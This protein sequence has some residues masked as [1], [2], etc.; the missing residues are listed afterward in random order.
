MDITPIDEARYVSEIQFALRAQEIDGARDRD[1]VS[2]RDGASNRDGTKRIEVSPA[3]TTVVIGDV[4]ETV[5]VESL[6]QVE[7]FTRWHMRFYLR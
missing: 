5:R 3:S 1:G 6:C 2:D 4:E 7:K